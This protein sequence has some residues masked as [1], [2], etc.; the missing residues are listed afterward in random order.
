M[1]VDV[2]TNMK[3]SVVKD[4]LYYM[5]RWEKADYSMDIQPT[6]SKI[7]FIDSIL[8]LDKVESIYSKL[9]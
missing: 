4:F 9:I 7:L 1:V 6:L 3:E 5:S 8:G 2:L